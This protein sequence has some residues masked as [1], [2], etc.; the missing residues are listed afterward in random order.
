MAATQ[1]IDLSRMTTAAVKSE[2]LNK[3]LTNPFTI[4]PIAGGGMIIAGWLIFD[5]GFL[6]LG[7]GIVAMIFGSSMFPINFYGRYTT[8]KI[9]YF[10]ELREENERITT[11]KLEEV[12]A[13]LDERNF[14]QGA[15][16]VDKIQQSM[17]SF[18]R[19]LNQKFEPHEFAHA[20][21]HGVAEQVMANTLL[22]LEQVVTLLMSIDS[23]DPD[24]IENRISEIGEAAD[25]KEENM[26]ASQKDEIEALNERWELRESSFTRIDELLSMNEKALTELGKIANTIATSNTTGSSAEAELTTAIESLNSLGDEAQKHWG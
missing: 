22:N 7:T 9:K 23:I 5:A 4:F 17:K 18:E 25:G 3:T 14:E 21:Y 15:L 11:K 2:V 24:Y 12:T 19:V 20:R 10:R 1:H 16:Q 6:F 8:F 13:F 26:T